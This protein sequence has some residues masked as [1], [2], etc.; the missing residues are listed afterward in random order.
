MR[1]IRGDLEERANIVH[2]QIRAAFGHYENVVQ[3]LQTERDERV[4]DLKHTMVMIERLM[5]FE[6]NIV[7][8]PRASAGIAFSS[9]R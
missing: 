1:D 2:D 9:C 4:S 3:Q 6:S 5:Q 7:G 8:K